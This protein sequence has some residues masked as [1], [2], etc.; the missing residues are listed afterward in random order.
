MSN[1]I[2]ISITNTGPGIPPDQLDKIFDRFYSAP[3]N[4]GGDSIQTSERSTYPTGEQGSGIGLALV[5]ELVELHHGTI[6]VQCKRKGTQSLTIFTIIVPLSREQ[7][8]E[9]EIIE[10]PLVRDKDE[11]ELISK[12]IEV[13]DQDYEEQEETEILGS[14]KALPLVLLIE[15]N[16]DMRTYIR[17]HMQSYYRLVVAADG[18]KGWYMAKRRT[19]DLII[20]DIMM[21]K[22]DGFQV[23][24][25]IKSDISTSH[26]PVILLTAR[27]ELKDKLTGLELGADDYIPKPFAIEELQVRIKN[28]I[29]QRQK[30]RERFSHEALFGIQDMSFNQTDEQFLQKIIK[31]INQHISDPHFTVQVLS[32]VI[33]MNQTTLN[34]KL[35][36]LTGQSPHNFIR[37][38]RLKKAAVFLRQK[39]VNVTEVAYEV[40]YKSLSHFTKA[41]QNQFGDT[42]S[43]FSA[44]H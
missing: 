32:A 29:E 15:D 14:P 34:Q 35:K 20:S 43:H 39:T 31:V 12:G 41:F 27:A 10:S 24:E 22:M 17:D 28:L 38:F 36:A 40:G 33:G 23:C 6:H 42:P 11:I 4:V 5:K 8:S 16:P 44:Y 21:P 13:P 3:L 7:Y 30:L 37:L 18:E 9:D 19:P 25:K 2:L 26:I 1:H